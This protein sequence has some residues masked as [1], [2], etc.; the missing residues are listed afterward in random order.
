MCVPR[1][2]SAER[3]IR[4]TQERGFRTGPWRQLYPA[5]VS[6]LTE[7]PIITV[8]MEKV[9][10]LSAPV[11]VMAAIFLPSYKRKREKKEEVREEGFILYHSGV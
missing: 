7:V 10:L 11:T 5:P 4:P 9:S 1:A 2:L 3:A 8:K 6:S